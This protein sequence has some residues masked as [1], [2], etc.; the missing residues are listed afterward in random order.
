MFETAK[1]LKLAMQLIDFICK[2][3]ISKISWLL[4]GSGTGT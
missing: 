2:K 3:S 4:R 1:K